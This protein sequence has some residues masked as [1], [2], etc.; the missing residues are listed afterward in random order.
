MLFAP[1][2]Y[3][4][5]GLIQMYSLKYGTIPIVRD[6][7]GLSDTIEEFDPAKGKGNGLM[8]GPYEVGG[9]IGAVERALALFRHKERW[10][11]LMNNAMA[12]DFSWDRS[13]RAY[14]NL[15]QKLVRS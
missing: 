6:T 5:C 15:Y 1:S 7:G 13:A 12:A 8:F 2:R 14:C 11:I 4:P 9:L 3:E 10:A